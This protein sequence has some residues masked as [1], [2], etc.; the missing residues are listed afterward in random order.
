MDR[1]IRNNKQQSPKGCHPTDA[2]ENPMSMTIVRGILLSLL[3]LTSPSGALAGNN[4]FR[5]VREQ[6]SVT[7]SRSETRSNT[8]GGHIPVGMLLVLGGILDN[9]RGLPILEC[10]ARNGDKIAIAALYSVHASGS[11]GAPKDLERADYW[12]MRGGIATPRNQA[13]RGYSHLKTLEWR[14]ALASDGDESLSACSHD[15]V[16]LNPIEHDAAAG[17][18]A[19]GD[20]LFDLYMKGRYTPCPKVKAALAKRGLMTQVDMGGE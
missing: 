18:K 7:K 1:S 15:N 4:G 9:E 12:A 11:H 2:K 10:A 5:D 3:I 16:Q 8:P 20:L 13:G 19:A 14:A 6:P 17:G